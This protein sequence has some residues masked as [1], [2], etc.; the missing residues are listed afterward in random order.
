MTCIFTREK[1]N[2]REKKRNEMVAFLV[3]ALL[4][5]RSKTGTKQFFNNNR[6]C[7]TGSTFKLLS[8]SILSSNPARPPK[9][10]NKC[11]ANITNQS[12]Q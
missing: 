4:A 2:E 12:N 3:N 6:V 5:N 1:K 10:I 11:L 8:S 7:Q 9:A